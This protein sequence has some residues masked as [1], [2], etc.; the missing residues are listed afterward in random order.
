MKRV[1]NK[2]MGVLCMAMTVF[3]VSTSSFNVSA[4]GFLTP[5]PKTQ[6]QPKTS[7]DSKAFLTKEKTTKSTSSYLTTEQQSVLDN[8][9]TDYGKINWDVQYSPKNMDGIIISEAAY[10]EDKYPYVLV[11]ITNIYNQ[12]V[13]FSGKGTA[14]GKGGKEV[15]SFSVFEEAIRPGSTI[16]K[17]VY[18]DGTPTGEIYWEDLDLPN[19]Y[20]ESTYWEG[21]WALSTDSDGY[22]KVDYSLT[23]DD[24]MT[25][26]YVTIVLLDKNGYVLDVAY[27]YNNTKGYS[28]SDSISFYTKDFGG[29]VVDGAMFTN[30]LVEK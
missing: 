26:G 20:G 21:D 1:N 18:C 19:V 16:L 4:A 28:V 24:Y 17:A 7:S 2:I 14:T 8:L 23:S 10:M 15:A 3:T 5:A 11:G 22:Y 30:P 12:D 6:V 9:E 13:T 29:K 27:D 25:P